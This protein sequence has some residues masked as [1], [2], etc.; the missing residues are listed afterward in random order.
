MEKGRS[1]QTNNDSKKFK[2]PEVLTVY[3]KINRMFL[4]YLE[5]HL[6]NFV[7]IL[8]RYEHCKKSRDG[9]IKVKV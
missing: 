6:N 9:T 7:A 1:F 3:E 8:N 4:K 5:H 2:K